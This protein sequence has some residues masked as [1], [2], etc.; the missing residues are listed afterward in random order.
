MSAGHGLLRITVG[1][2]AVYEDNPDLNGQIVSHIE[3]W[4]DSVEVGTIVSIAD[5]M[6]FEIPGRHGM[7]AEIVMDQ[8]FPPVGGPCRIAGV[9]GVS[10]EG[11]LLEVATGRPKFIKRTA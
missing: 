6:N 10:M 11:P 4:R 7:P 5:M 8:V 3:R 1:K 2:E 9:E